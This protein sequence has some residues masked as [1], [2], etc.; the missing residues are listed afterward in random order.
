M[1]TKS[2]LQVAHEAMRAARGDTAPPSLQDFLA[3]AEGDLPEADAAR[4]RELLVA[5]PDLL[6]AATMPFPSGDAAPGEDGY[7]SEHEVARQWKSFQR[8]IGA[9]PADRSSSLWRATAALA[10]ALAVILGVLLWQSAAN[11]RRLTRQ[12]TEP[13]VAGYQLLLP[14][15]Q[16]GPGN[17]P[18]LTPT[19]DSYLLAA[20]II[21]ATPFDRYRLELV[22]LT[23]HRTLWR[24]DDLARPDSDTFAILL[25]RETFHP[26]PFQVV[27]YGVN[28]TLAEK[29]A[30]YTVVAPGGPPVPNP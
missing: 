4:V 25:P 15:G 21:G 16:R 11:E 27:L 24:R 29:L 8:S 30:T 26:G 12:L 17:A 10:A 18:T 19:G 5:H 6:R 20:A 13:R 1:I 3:Y 28:G 7:L 14:D 23:T 9:A 22:D 2:E